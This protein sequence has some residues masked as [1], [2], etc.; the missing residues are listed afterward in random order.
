MLAEHLGLW[1][2]VASPNGKS[3]FHE[4]AALVVGGPN[5]GIV[6]HSSQPVTFE[7]AESVVK[8]GVCHSILQS[9]EGNAVL[10][11]RAYRGSALKLC[12]RMFRLYGNVE[13]IS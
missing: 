5:Q 11:K 10:E 9:Y 4:F 8:F 7:S 3:N 2:K 6:S 12:L 1:Q 13:G